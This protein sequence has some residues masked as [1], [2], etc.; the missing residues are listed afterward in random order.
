MAL[1]GEPEHSVQVRAQLDLPDVLASVFLPAHTRNSAAMTSPSTAHATHLVSSALS[2]KSHDD[3]SAVDTTAAAAST[4]EDTALLPYKSQRDGRQSR[5]QSPVKKTRELP[6]ITRRNSSAGI[7]RIPVEL[8]REGK[9]QSIAAAGDGG[10]GGSVSSK[11]G[12]V[13]PRGTRMPSSPEGMGTSTPA[14][15]PSASP[16]PAT[17]IPSPYKTQFT[18]KTSGVVEEA[19]LHLSSLMVAQVN[20]ESARVAAVALDRRTKAQARAQSEHTARV[21][22]KRALKEA[23]RL[24]RTSSSGSSKTSQ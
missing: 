8:R 24:R 13:L 2:S 11:K 5:R 6:D 10:G 18:S 22:A 17:I 4:K 1:A 20:A 23:A 15:L 3:A 14:A 12:M 7:N 16:P 19:A 21:E 9:K